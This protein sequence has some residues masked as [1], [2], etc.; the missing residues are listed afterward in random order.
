MANLPR[1]FRLLVIVGVLLRQGLDE[2]LFDR[3]PA[4]AVAFLRY[5]SPWYW[6][7]AR[8][9][10]R[11]QRARQALEQL[12]PLFVKFGQLL[13][14][15]RDLLPTDIA[16]ELSQLQDAVPPFAGSRAMTIVTR[17][18]R[19]P[20]DAVFERFDPEPLASASIAQVHAARLKDGREVVIKV[21]RPGIERAIRRDIALLYMLAGIAERHS[22]EG[23]RLRLVEVVQDYQRTILDELDLLREAANAVQLRRNFKD[24]DRL[25][26]PEVHLDHCRSNVLVMERIYGVP[27]DDLAALR[28][29]GIDLVQLAET[30][31]EIFYTQVFDH[32]FFHADMHPGNLFVAPEGNYIAVDFGI[33]GSLTLEDQ[34]YLAENFLAFF[35]RDYKRV[36]E[37]HIRAGWVPR[38]TRMVEFETAI[39]T[40]CEPIF[41]KPL[42]EISLAHVLH[43]LFQT[44][45]RFDMAVQPQLVLLQ[46]TILNIEGIG[47]QL[48]PEFDLWKTGKPFFQRWVQNNIG[49]KA[50]ASEL[51]QRIPNWAQQLPDVPE[52]ILSLLK[53][54]D[55]GQLEIQWRSPQLESLPARIVQLEKRLYGAII[56]GS[57]MI[58]AALLFG[59]DRGP[60]GPHGIPLGSWL[61]GA[62]AV[63]I[64]LFNFRGRRN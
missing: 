40:V 59:L 1:L 35:N 21:V 44:A 56:A 41:D 54:A 52:Q 48:N 22:R 7:R 19:Q 10:S 55:E 32:N 33:V 3:G 37:A 2:F 49:I 53:K 62:G 64:L 16:D 36:A 17:A 34:R 61:S 29:A 31:V 9:Q 6:L 63:L 15:R 51:R 5:L 26:I 50:V 38:E 8:R 28:L 14:T 39:R 24:N 60:A 4:R 20:L 23:R 46:K 42:A 27:I 57:L 47:R 12:G 43:Q 30:G 13:S 25:Y 58:V 45:R 18:L 11:G